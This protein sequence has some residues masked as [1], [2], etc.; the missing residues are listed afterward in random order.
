MVFALAQR[1]VSVERVLTDN[2]R[3]Y[4][5]GVFLEVASHYG[6]QQRR[7]AR[8]VPRR[9]ARPKRSS[10]RSNENGAY[11]RPYQSN[12]Q[13]LEALDTFLVD[14]NFARPHT[15]I[16]NQPPASRL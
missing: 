2:A 13:R 12:A 10:R 15:A 16:G 6:I 8:S 1:G 3:C 11:R 14:Y 4:Y 5:S 9:T 7:R